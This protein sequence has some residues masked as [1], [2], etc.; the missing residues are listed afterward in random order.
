MQAYVSRA[1]ATPMLSSRHPAAPLSS[2][3]ICKQAQWPESSHCRG[4]ATAV[5]WEGSFHPPPGQRDEEG[6]AAECCRYRTT[7]TCLANRTSDCCSA[8]LHRSEVVT[9]ERAIKFGAVPPG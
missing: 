1:Q 7:P 4:S 3:G 6:P 9:F 5:I 2:V 8:K